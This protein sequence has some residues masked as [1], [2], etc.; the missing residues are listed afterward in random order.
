MS[1]RVLGIDPGT[2]V[3]GYAVVDY[4][5]RQLGQLLGQLIEC[6]VIRTNPRQP[7]SRRLDDL[8]AGVTELIERHDPTVL[9]VE[10]IFYGQNV[11]TT[12]SLGHARGVILLAGTRAGVEIA[13]FTPATV[14]KS[15]VFSW[16]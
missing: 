4:A 12:V 14:K 6:G 3:T 9:A 13:E 16:H 7:I 5:N 15:V 10:S 8:F 1:A 11:R 2:A